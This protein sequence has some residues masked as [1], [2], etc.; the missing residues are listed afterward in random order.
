[1]YGSEVKLYNLYSDHDNHDASMESEDSDDDYE[2]DKSEGE[3]IVMTMM[4][5]IPK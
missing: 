2:H 5:L 3:D 1:M 4:R